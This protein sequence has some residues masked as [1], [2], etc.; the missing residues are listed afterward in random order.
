MPSTDDPG[1][2]A[3]QL[4]Q[5]DKPLSDSEYKEYRMNLEHALATAERREKLAAYIAGVAFVVAFVLMF[6]GGSRVFGS[7]DPWSKDATIL[8]VTLGIVY[9]IAMLTWPI[10]LATGFSRFRPRIREIK[11]QI[12]DTNVLALRS[13]IAA[14]RKQMSAMTGGDG[15]TR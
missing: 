2:F 7:F 8:S 15:P 10:A 14:L 13:E 4:L 1:G 9:A 11:D 12:R 3:E 6:A 5:L